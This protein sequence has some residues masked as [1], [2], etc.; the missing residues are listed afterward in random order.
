MYHRIVR[1]RIRSLFDA[2][3][4]GDAEPVLAAFTR[5]GEHI[6]IGDHAMSGRRTTPASIRAWYERLY[7][8]LPDISF[9]IHAISVAGTPWNTIATVEWSET[10]SATDGMRTSASG[11]HVVHLAWGRMTRL[12]ILTDTAALTRTLERT[13]DSS[14]GLSQAPPI[15]DAPGWPAP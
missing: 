4:R 13:V 5:S 6:F 7:Q 10:N 9:T 12:I 1:R 14:S 8:L 3:N 11:M 2:V 15:D